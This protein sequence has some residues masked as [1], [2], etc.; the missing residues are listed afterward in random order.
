MTV[1]QCAG[2]ETACH[3]TLLAPLLSALANTE[4]TRAAATGDTRCVFSRESGAEYR[5]HLTPNVLLRCTV[6]TRCDGSVSRSRSN[7]LAYGDKSV[8]V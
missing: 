1:W 6:S 7:S 4:R 8:L 3:R 2:N 5:H